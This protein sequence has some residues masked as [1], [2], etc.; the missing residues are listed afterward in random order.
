MTFGAAQAGKLF[1]GFPAVRR[2]EDRGV[3]HACIS[4]VRIGQR[5]LE[6]PD[7]L[8]LPRMLRAVVK[9]VRAHFAFIHEHVALALGHSIRA[10]PTCG[11]RFR[12]IPRF[13]T[14]IGALDDLPEPPAGLRGTYAV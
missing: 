8:E 5:G 9:L 7:A 4:G 11:F 6:M 14:V 3:F 12:W 10:P 1:P 2:F 13:A